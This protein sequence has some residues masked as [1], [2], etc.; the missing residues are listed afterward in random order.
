MPNWSEDF[1]SRSLE[2]VIRSQAENRAWNKELRERNTTLVNNRLSHL[3]DQVEYTVIRKFPFFALL[4]L[5]AFAA[6]W[7]QWRGPAA[8]GVAEGAHP[9]ATWSATR[10]IVWKIEVPG[11][12][13]S[14]PIVWGDRVFLTTDIEGEV[15]PDA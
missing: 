9:P 8:T 14:Q 1:S 3:I 12:G 7:P 13:H 4:S 11:R 2:D 15:L 10:N 5:T 6:D